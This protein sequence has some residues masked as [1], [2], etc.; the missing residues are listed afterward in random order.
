MQNKGESLGDAEKR[1]FEILKKDLNEL[2][3]LGQSVFNLSGEVVTQWPVMPNKK[4]PRARR[5]STILL[6][7]ISNDL[8]WA[9]RLA[10][11]G[12]SIQSLS[13]TAS[14]YEVAFTVF[15]I[16]KNEN[17]AEEWLNY[18]DPK[19]PFR[20]A[21]TLTEHVASKIE[22]LNVKQK[23]DDIYKRYRQLCWAKHA[24]PI[25]QRQLG[26]TRKNDYYIA[27]P[28]PD[29]SDKSIRYT[30]Y[31]LLHASGLAMTAIH[32]FIIDFIPESKHPTLI[33]KLKK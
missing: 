3:D 2:N 21:R 24:N 27:F 17:L 13:L 4:V 8:L 18:N 22:T 28:G 19:N 26:I 5:V 20:D 31:S 6:N 30:W 32:S 16:G 9:S 10:T 29:T 25:L 7:R 11:Y 23:V 33:K 12:Y 14:I 1:A 15:Y